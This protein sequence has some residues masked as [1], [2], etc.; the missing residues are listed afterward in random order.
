MDTRFD[1]GDPP[2]DRG[3]AALQPDSLGLVVRS[4]VP[5]RPGD[6]SGRLLPPAGH[7]PARDLTPANHVVEQS[8]GSLTCLARRAGSCR[9]CAFDRRAKRIADALGPAG[10]ATSGVVL[11][12]AL[13]I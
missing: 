13:H 9:E 10:R 11:S 8:L 6:A 5:D 2:F 12:R 3:E 7:L 1:G 4:Q